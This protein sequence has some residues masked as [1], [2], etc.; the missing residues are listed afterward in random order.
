LRDP[1]RQTALR[2]QM[3]GVPANLACLAFRDRSL[4]AAGDWDH[5]FSTSDRLARYKLPVEL[6]G[7]KHRS[8]RKESSSSFAPQ[9]GTDGILLRSGKKSGSPSAPLRVNKPPHSKR[10]RC[11]PRQ[12]PRFFFFLFHCKLTTECLELFSVRRAFA[13]A[14]AIEGTVDKHKRD[15]KEHC[16]ENVRQGAALRSRQ[17]HG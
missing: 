6:P 8:Q 13:D 12:A 5:G 15:H 14:H 16:R 2:H 1:C 11:P 9:N 7:A 17:L 4:L 3:A 10:T